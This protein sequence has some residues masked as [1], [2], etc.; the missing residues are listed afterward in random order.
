MGN[1]KQYLVVII[2]SLFLSL[3]KYYS[4]KSR[5]YYEC[6]KEWAVE[7]DRTTINA[8]EIH[9]GIQNTFI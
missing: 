7:Y 6:L 1:S 4:S 3:L 5:A 2:A 9:K 8:E